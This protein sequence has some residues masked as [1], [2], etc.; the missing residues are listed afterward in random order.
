MMQCA[1][2]S[3]I[4]AGYRLIYCYLFLTTS[5]A[6]GSNNTLPNFNAQDIEPKQIIKLIDVILKNTNHG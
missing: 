5:V 6:T 4:K 2:G 3:R 1:D